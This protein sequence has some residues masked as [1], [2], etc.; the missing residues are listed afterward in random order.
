MGAGPLS[1]RPHC[2]AGLSLLPAP[3]LVVAPLLSDEEIQREEAQEDSDGRE[4]RG[5]QKLGTEGEGDTRPPGSWS[6]VGPDTGRCQGGGSRGS[7]EETPEEHAVLLPGWEP[8]TW[9]GRG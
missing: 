1:A 5:S 9:G 3:N 4:G 7:T 8:S 6:A 2:P